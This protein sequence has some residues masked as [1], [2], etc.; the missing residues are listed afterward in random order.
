MRKE[1]VFS[2][3]IMSY[4]STEN[5]LEIVSVM[6]SS[7][8]ETLFSHTFYKNNKDYLD[9]FTNID[10]FVKPKRE[11][12]KKNNVIVNLDDYSVSYS[13]NNQKVSEEDLRLVMSILKNEMANASPEIAKKKALL[14]KYINDIKIIKALEVEGLEF[15]EEI[16]KIEKQIE[17]LK[18][19]IE[20][21]LEA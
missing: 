6:D 9:N 7:Q 5:G 12:T 4:E 21:L 2:K 15:G 10:L 1:K 11:T 8:K 3:Y 19:E 18:E 16:E 20:E 17:E 14:T 13:N